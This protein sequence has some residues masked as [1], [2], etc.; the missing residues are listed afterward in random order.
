MVLGRKQTGGSRG[1]CLIFPQMLKVLARGLIFKKNLMQTNH[2]KCPSC[3]N[4]IDVQGALS[5]DVEQKFKLQYEKQLQQSLAQITADKNKLE[6]DQKIF[7]EKK[8]QENELFQ[9]KLQ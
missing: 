2:I 1:N 3:G 5:A 6:E 8:K 9:K 7:E 4:E